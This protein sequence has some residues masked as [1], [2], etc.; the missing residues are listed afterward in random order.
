M[1]TLQ[2]PIQDL[3]ARLEARA[4]RIE[5]ERQEKMKIITGAEMNHFTNSWPRLAEKLA[6]QLQN[7]PIY[8]EQHHLSEAENRLSHC[9]SCKEG[10]KCLEVNSRDSAGNLRAVDNP[11]ASPASLNTDGLIVFEP[12]TKWA[13]WQRRKQLI[14]IG[15]PKIFLN[16]DFNS[17]QP[18][19]RG[20]EK[21]LEACK[22]F[23]GEIR[24]DNEPVKGLLFSGP[25]G[26]GKTHLAVSTMIALLDL[27]VKDLRFETVPK[28]LGLARREINRPKSESRQ[29]PLEIAARA[30]ILVLDDIASEKASEWTA[31]QLFL[32]I[33]AR[34]EDQLPT[35]ITTNANLSD[36]EN[37]IGG[38]SVSRIFQMCRGVVLAGEDHRRTKGGD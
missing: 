21:A 23:V 7:R 35:L 31:E 9:E 2:E 10:E 29:D 34:Y 16:S 17:F 1:Q 11:G 30:S 8:M 28:M 20:H 15:I 37:R 26:T 19:N 6:L 25:Y 18:K 4:A 33:N 32:L 3:Q 13:T 12:C 5:Q 38:A 27:G 22:Q 24:S 14:G 36:L